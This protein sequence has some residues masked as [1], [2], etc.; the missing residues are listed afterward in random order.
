[1]LNL[2]HPPTHEQQWEMHCQPPKVT[3]SSGLLNRLKYGEAPLNLADVTWTKSGVNNMPRLWRCARVHQEE[4][5]GNG[6]G[7]EATLFP[8]WNLKLFI[9]LG[10]PNLENDYFGGSGG[11]ARRTKLIT[12]WSWMN[13]ILG[14][15]KDQEPI[16][17]VYSPV[18]KRE[19][20]WYQIFLVLE[21][22]P[23]SFFC[24]C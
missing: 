21:G 4:A 20:H 7:S 3:S 2:T 24:F 8:C 5:R 1:M 15:F 18:R 16:Y 11:H 13:D 9:D 17:N 10:R 6:G 19:G 23:C 22:I 12:R 14:M